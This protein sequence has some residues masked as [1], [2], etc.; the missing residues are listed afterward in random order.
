M[1]TSGTL[2][3]H[4]R[5][6]DWSRNRTSPRVGSSPLRSCRFVSQLGLDPLDGL[7]ANALIVLRRV[8]PAKG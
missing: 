2:R 4:R 6:P 8:R 1:A 7:G 5:W 3:C